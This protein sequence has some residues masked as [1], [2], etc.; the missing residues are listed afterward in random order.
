[1]TPSPQIS[2]RALL[3]GAGG[4]SLAAVLAA[5]T[6]GGGSGGSGGS[7][8][9][10]TL[11]M[12]SAF[13]AAM[14]KT[15]SG[16]S[17]KYGVQLEVQPKDYGTILANFQQAAPTGSGPD[18]LDVNIDFIGPLTDA[19]LVEALDFGSRLK[20]LDKRAITGYTVDGK[21][22][23]LPLAVEATNFW[24]NPA[25]VDSP[26]S[27]WDDLAKLGADLK[28]KG[29]KY[30]FLMD[31]NAYVFQGMLTAF[32]SW[33]FK[34]N[35]DGSYDVDNVGIDNA[36]AVAAL[37]FFSDAVANG[38]LAYVGASDNSGLTASTAGDAWKAGQVGVHFSGPWM[39]DTYSKAGKFEIDKIPAGP[40]GDAVSWLSARGLVVNANSKNAALAATFL[41]DY[42]TADGPMST[43]AKTTAKLSAWTP[44][45]KSAANATT[46]AFGAAAPNAQPIPQNAALSG[47]WTPM[48]DGLT[49]ILEGKSN[50]ADVAANAAQQFR[51]SIAAAKK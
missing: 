25:V 1:M 42:L 12:D 46:A 7:N 18:L 32:G 19:K 16:F 13:T 31:V 29:I 20:S 11:W 28:A 43:W 8:Q 47:F 17:G 4:L 24:R 21:V 41:T 15:V 27:T 35:S 14:K 36:G 34:Q 48:T 26:V 6:A 50:A 9:K 2:R 38:W 40:G 23:G 5:C 51:A 33:V 37:Q 39:L 44:V 30:P 45:Q 49:L 3:A 22:Y 10:L